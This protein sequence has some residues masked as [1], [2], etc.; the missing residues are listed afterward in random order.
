VELNDLIRHRLIDEGKIESIQNYNILKSA[1]ISAKEKQLSNSYH[2]DQVIIFNKQANISDTVIK[3]GEKFAIQNVDTGNNLISIS[4]IG[5]KDN[6]V[7]EIDPVKHSKTFQIFNQE[8]IA[9]GKGD[10]LQFT[11]NDKLYNSNN[12]L[13]K[14]ENGLSGQVK[15]ADENQLIVETKK[16]DLYININLND[17]GS[18][19]FFDYNYALTNYKSQGSTVDHLIAFSPTNDNV[20]SLNS[21]Y[22]AATR[23]KYDLTILTDDVKNLSKKVTKNQHKLTTTDFDYSFSEL[24]DMSVINQLVD[25]ISQDSN[26]IGFQNSSIEYFEDYLVNDIDQVII[27]VVPDRNLENEIQR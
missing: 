27:E 11:K 18:Y 7:I 4:K 3:A 8:S 23:A 26:S 15:S 21:F 10:S 19:S 20:H 24:D 14:I 1:N 16:G 22:V 12:V 9:I 17:K 25:E 6:Q 13:V 2:N 5:V